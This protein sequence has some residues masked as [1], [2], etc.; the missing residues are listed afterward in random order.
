MVSQFNPFEPMPSGVS[1]SSR[2]NLP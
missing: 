1:A 2:L